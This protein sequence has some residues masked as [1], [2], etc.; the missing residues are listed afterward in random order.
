MAD[1]SLENER[2]SAVL[3]TASGEEIIFVQVAGLVARRIICDLK[4]GQNVKSGER[5]GIIRFGSRADIYL[6]SKTAQ[7]KIMIGQTMIG[8]ETVIAELNE[9]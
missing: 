7:L 5:Y 2:Q 4:E 8:G 1:A 3:K 9:K 6:P